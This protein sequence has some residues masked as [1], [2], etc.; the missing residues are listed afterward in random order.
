MF[1]M[2]TVR[3]QALDLR[4]ENVRLKEALEKTEA[5]V[6]YIAMMSDIELDSGE[7]DETEAENDEQ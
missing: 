7:T 6:E 1:K 4:H 5:D 3:E 2:K